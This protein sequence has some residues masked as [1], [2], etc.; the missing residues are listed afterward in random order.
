MQCGL[1][2][3]PV[4]GVWKDKKNTPYTL[5]RTVTSPAMQ[6]AVLPYGLAWWVHRALQCSLSR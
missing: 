1:E 4:S 6:A 5:N 2:G 3:V